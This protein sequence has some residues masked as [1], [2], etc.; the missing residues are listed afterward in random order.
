[1][2]LFKKRYLEQLIASPGTE[3]TNITSKRHGHPLGDINGDAQKF[4]T[5][6]RLSCTPVNTPV[7][8]TGAEGIVR[9]RDLTLL[10]KH[11]GHIILT[12]SLAV[13]LI[14]WLNFV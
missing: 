9:S 1:M 12:K 13:S 8:L 7:M 5:A 10:V 6:L 3:V 4:I 2:C 11:G 14:Q